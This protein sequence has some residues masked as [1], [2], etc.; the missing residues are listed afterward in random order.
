[1]ARTYSYGG[2]VGIDISKLRPRGAK[3][4]NTAKETTGAVSFMPTF[5]TV[6][7]T[8]GQCGRRGALM[9]SISVNHPDVY[10]FVDI[11]A[12]TDSINNA[13][14]SIRVNDD[15]MR[16][17]DENKDY[18]LH[19]PCDMTINEKELEAIPEYGV[20]TKVDT[21]SGPVYLKKIKASDLFNKLV[22]NNWEYAEQGDF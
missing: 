13:N 4:N 14:I 15:F 18:L 5:D 21:A 19:W 1:M 7:G 3:V 16:A 12:N 11:K 2:G 6:T 10:E 9:I 20:L 17:V 22:Q 8:I